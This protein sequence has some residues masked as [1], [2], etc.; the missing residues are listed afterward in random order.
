VALTKTERGKFKKKKKKKKKKIPK[1]TLPRVICEKAKWD[2]FQS[3]TT[4]MPPL[5]YI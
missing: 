4:P 5:W 2:L 1:I 3:I